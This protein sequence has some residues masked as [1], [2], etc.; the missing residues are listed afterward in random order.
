MRMRL[1][2]GVLW[3][4]CIAIAAG[5]SKNDKSTNPD[6]GGGGGGGSTSSFSAQVGAFVATYFTAN[7]EAYSSLDAMLP[8]VAASLSAQ[9]A[10]GGAP[11][12][13]VTCFDGSV[14]GTTY[15][16]NG[17]TYVAGSGTGAAGNAVRFVLYRL[18]T[19]NQPVLTDS[20]G[21]IEVRCTVT[22]TRTRNVGFSVVANGL[23]PL[24][25]DG[26]AV[27]DPG[28]GNYNLNGYLAAGGAALVPIALFGQYDPV[29][30]TLGSEFYVQDLGLNFA[31]IDS[32]GLGKRTIGAGAINSADPL[33]HLLFR[34][35]GDIA[36]ETLTSGAVYYGDD[37]SSGIDQLVACMNGGT[38]TTPTF[39]APDASCNL[40]G[41]PIGSPM[42]AANLA[43]ALA[44]YQAL[45]EVHDA[46]T[47][48]LLQALALPIP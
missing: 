39:S 5:C 6:T 3:V 26:I 46:I 34:L 48:L 47:D 21:F 11:E 8:Y 18:N 32:V 35:S 28:V 22:N 41:Y 9:P 23:T 2:H 30:V 13:G 27:E 29:E 36:T 14:A 38:L 25:A 7:D 45:R 12:G 40:I 42:S 4:A 1:M 20:I 24:Q 10:R 19:S 44:G 17:T 31:T 43:A 16:F 37:N 15:I 33:Y